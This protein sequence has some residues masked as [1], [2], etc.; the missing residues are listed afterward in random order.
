MRDLPADTLGVDVRHDFRP[1][2]RLLLRK[3][4]LVRRLMR[5]ISKADAVY[6]ATPPDRAGEAMGWHLL[7]L[8]PTLE[9]K[10]VC[11]VAL[12]ALSP[13]AIRAA[14]DRPRSLDLNSVEAEETRRIMDRLVSHLISPL[15]NKALN[16]NAS[17]SRAEVI[18][19]RLLVERE[20]E[21]AA[22]TPKMT[23]TLIARLSVE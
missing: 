21:I 18:C 16:I 7:A 19:L 6:I 3:G 23:W 4:N 1:T 20:R 2:Y 15:A 10:P 14:F 12:N 8:S 11:R 5:A 9:N 22:Y 17:F 13:D